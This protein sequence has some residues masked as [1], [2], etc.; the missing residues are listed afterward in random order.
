MEKEYEHTVDVEFIKEHPD[1]RYIIVEAPSHSFNIN[2]VH[3]GCVIEKNAV[4]WTIDKG[5]F[6]KEYC[7]TLYMVYDCKFIIDLD[8][9]ETL[10]TDAEHYLE[11]SIPNWTRAAE[12]RIQSVAKEL[13][14]I[15]ELILTTKKGYSDE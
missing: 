5:I 3:V 4:D 11:V 13:Q 7:K 8:H 15:R 14:E 12:K 9:Y 6:G 10:L 2:R 1:L